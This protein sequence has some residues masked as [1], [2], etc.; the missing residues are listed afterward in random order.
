[1][2][3]CSFLNGALTRIAF[4]LAVIFCMYTLPAVTA[5]E[6]VYIGGSSYGSFVDG[7]YIVYTNFCDDRFNRTPDRNPHGVYWGEVLYQFIFAIPNIYIH[8]IS[9]G[10][11]IPVYKSEGKSTDPWIIN[12][13]VYWHED[14]SLDAFY[15]GGDPN[16]PGSYIYSVPVGNISRE[17]AENYSLLNPDVIPAGGPEYNECIR[18]RP[19]HTTN[20]TEFVPEDGNYS[21]YYNDPDTG[22]RTL[23][24]AGLF[25]KPHHLPQINDE[26]IFWED[27]RT[28]IPRLYVYDIKT[29]R[30]YQIA[31]EVLS[32]QYECSVDGDIIAWNSDGGDLWYENFSGLIEEVQPEETPEKIPEPTE[33][34][35]GGL[36][37]PV[38]ISASIFFFAF[39]GGKKR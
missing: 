38:S 20:L 6:P 29:G 36:I 10:E 16:P 7:D 12:G 14:R 31:P 32:S 27:Y 35:T 21:I 18:S 22:N 1:M 5:A 33:A 24:A 8:N 11:T 19:N 3:N 37:V 23:V 25:S 39:A 34:G 17:A 28:G 15:M 9:S 4:V 13:T 30:D 26:R 2:R